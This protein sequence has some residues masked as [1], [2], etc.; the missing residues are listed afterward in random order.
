VVFNWGWRVGAVTPATGGSAVP[1][2]E[3][4]PFWSQRGLI[5]LAVGLP[6]AETG[7]LTL[8]G[9]GSG[10]PLAPQASAIGPLGVFH[11]L[12][13]LFVYH[14][15][16]P[17]FVGGLVVLIGLRSLVVAF[18]AY[19]AWPAGEGGARFGPLLRRSLAATAL[20]AVF[21]AP[22]VTL[23]FGAAVVPLSWL[24][25]AALPPALVTLVL[26][27][28]GGIERRWWVR[29]PPWRSAAWMAASVVVLSVAALVIAGRP[30]SV[31]LPVSGLVGAFN[32]WAW[33]NA[34]RAIALRLPVRR[35]I[36]WAPVAVGVLFIVVVAGARIGF[37]VAD[38]A[39]TPVPVAAARPGGPGVLVV[40]G[41]ASDCCAEGVEFQAGAPGFTVEQFSYLGLDGDGAPKPHT[42]SATDRDLRVLAD[43]MDTQVGA[44]AVR[45]GGPV[46]IVA[47]SEGTLVAAAFLAEHP[48]ALVSRVA[49]LSPIVD[50][51]RVSYPSVGDGRG[52]VAGAQLRLLTDFIDELAPFA[53]TTDGPL[54]A[55]L[56]EQGPILHSAV[57]CDT[58]GSVPRLLVTPLADSV[59]APVVLPCAVDTVVV[60]GFHGGLR[61]RADVRSMVVDWLL[62][63]P[64]DDEAVWETLDRL[65][66]GVAAAWQVPPLEAG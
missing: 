44:L 49:L 62:G 24:V 19:S 58:A 37:A 26:V 51:A 42:G 10:Y 41:F 40:G 66:T 60:P 56:L 28:H 9:M 3:L 59:S 48:D 53:V 36:P 2:D 17:G 34:T 45:T 43:L 50:P 20:V 22:W 5:A 16:V 23:L 21:L 14:A 13:W 46:A 8:L 15:S 47:E 11:D 52:M 7:V 55:S 32:G 1:P 54:A 39:E 25:F 30:A 31:A 35:R 29:M 63:I 64:V 4:R 38:D 6:V 27:A 61:G 57:V 65:L 18:L 12:R 33:Y